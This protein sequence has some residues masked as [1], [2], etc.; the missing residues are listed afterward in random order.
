MLSCAEGLSQARVHGNIAV[1]VHRKPK[2]HLLADLILALAK[3]MNTTKSLTSGPLA[4]RRRFR[5]WKGMVHGSPETKDRSL[6]HS[7]SPQRQYEIDACA[8]LPLSAVP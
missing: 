4:S 1:C 3:W 5:E 7:F 6:G 8:T 2:L